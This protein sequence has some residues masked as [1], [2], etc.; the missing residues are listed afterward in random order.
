MTAANGAPL[1][2]LSI[3]GSID[4]GN[5]FSSTLNVSAGQSI[6]IQVLGQ[7]APVGTSNSHANTTSIVSGT[8]GINSLAFNLID[9]AGG[10]FNVASLTLGSG[11]NGGSGF[12]VGTVSGNTL[13]DVRPIQAPGVFAGATSPSVLLTGTFTVGSFSGSSTETLGG[14][15]ATTGTT[16]GAFKIDSGSSKVITT[17][18][19]AS[20]DPYV[21]YSPLTLNNTAAA[22]EPASLA[23]LGVSA[24][25]LLLRRRK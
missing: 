7:L 8:D 19:E 10:A 12:G 13:S 16:S 9:S 17:T 1:I 24:A 2:N 22:P 14:A 20:T 6:A 11:W 4:G 5:T 15:W 23:M 21:G 18:T 25:G 3:Q